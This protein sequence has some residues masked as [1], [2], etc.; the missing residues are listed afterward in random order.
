VTTFIKAEEQNISLW[1]YVYILNSEIDMI[2]EQNKLV[3]DEI[4]QYEEKLS[5]NS[6][7]KLKTREQLVKT[8]EEMKASI[9]DKQN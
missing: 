2:D 1:N 6:S 8:S 3:E 5:M 7:D 9:A 4:K